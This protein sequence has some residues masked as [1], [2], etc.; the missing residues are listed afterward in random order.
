MCDC[1]FYCFRVVIVPSSKHSAL[2]SSNRTP[3]FAAFMFLLDLPIMY[4]IL[5]LRNGSSLKALFFSTFSQ[6]YGEELKNGFSGGLISSTLGPYRWSANLLEINFWVWMTLLVP[7]LEEFRLVES[8]FKLDFFLIR[9]ETL[10]SLMLN[11][12][13][14]YGWF[15]K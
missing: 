1:Y 2:I 14:N 6:I 7:G 8:E 15:P 5:A 10:F 11:L 4:Y 12:Y 13:N 9:R 3:D